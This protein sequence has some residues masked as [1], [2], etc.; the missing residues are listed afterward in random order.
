MYKTASPYVKELLKG[1]IQWHPFTVQTLDYAQQEDKMIFV[2]IGNIANTEARNQA[3]TLFS[4]QQ[5]ID[6]LQDNFICIALDTE[7]V[8]EAYLIGMD[9]LLI[10]EQKISIMA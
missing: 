10:N 9:L 8:P 7:D 1:K 4:N 3:Y 5:V 2:H 6:I